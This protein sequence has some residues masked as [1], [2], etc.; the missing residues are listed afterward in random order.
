MLAEH[1]SITGLADIIESV[2]SKDVVFPSI[3]VFRETSGESVQDG[4]AALRLDKELLSRGYL[5]ERT[6]AEIEKAC[7]D[8]A[9]IDYEA[10]LQVTRIASLTMNIYH[11]TRLPIPPSLRA[12]CVQQYNDAYQAITAEHE[13]K[14]G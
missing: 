2:F 5:T 10:S 14:H 3:H 8:Q 6:K 1:T 12:Y 11:N 7:R 13:R 9:R 4:Q